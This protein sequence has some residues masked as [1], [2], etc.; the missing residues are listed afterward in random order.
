MPRLLLLSWCP[1]SEYGRLKKQV[2][3]KYTLNEKHSLPCWRWCHVPL[4]F[5][6]RFL[7]FVLLLMW[8]R[9]VKLAIPHY[10]MFLLLKIIHLVLFN[11]LQHQGDLVISG[12]LIYHLFVTDLLQSI[13]DRHFRKFVLLVLQN[14]REDC[15][16]VCV[17]SKPFVDIRSYMSVLSVWGDI[18]ICL[19]SHRW[20][21]SA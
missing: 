8:Y 13:F 17:R 21:D 12:K 14:F 20:V 11:S 9:S 10:Y 2:Q 15:V 7:R 19:W 4:C 1:V 5:L 16:V 18:R 3:V 6:H